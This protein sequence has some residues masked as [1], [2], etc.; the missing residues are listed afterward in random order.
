MYLYVIYNIKC[1]F[2]HKH[3]QAHVCM[4]LHRNTHMC[5]VFICI[6]TQVHIFVCICKSPCVCGHS[7]IYIHM[8]IYNDSRNF[9]LKFLTKNFKKQNMEV[10]QT[11]SHQN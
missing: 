11:R 6:G 3:V 1:I 10:N 8:C 2:M 7:H 4:C 5:G 9:N